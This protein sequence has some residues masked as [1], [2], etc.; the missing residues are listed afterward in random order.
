[1]WGASGLGGKPGRSALELFGASQATAG[2]VAEGEAGAVRELVG[3]GEL[4]VRAFR[5]RYGRDLLKLQKSDSRKAIFAPH[6]PSSTSVVAVVSWG[7]DGVYYLQVVFR[8]SGVGKELSVD[9]AYLREYIEFSRSLNFA[10]AAADLFVSPPTLRAHLHALEEEVGAPLTVKRAG[11][12]E[13]SPAGRLFLKRARAIVKLVEE[14]AE[15]CRALAEASSSMV[16]GTLEYA[17][18]EELL[19]RALLAF[20]RNYPGRCLEVLMASGAY[21]NTEAVAGGKADLSIFAQVRRR[22]EEGEVLP[23]ALPAGVGAFPFAREECR[24]WMNRSCPLFEEDRVRA[25]DLEGFTMLLGSSANMER[26]GRAITEWFAGVG[27]TVEP[28]NQPC[29]NYLDLYLSAAG[30]TFGIALGGAH[31][32]LRASSDIR[33]FAVDDFTVLCD[34]YVIYNEE[35]IGENG[36]LFV[37]CLKESISFSS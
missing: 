33:I 21:A 2:G 28:D 19:T 7:A 22:D 18:F 27:V 30:E 5:K 15:E 32:G 4:A 31:S 1:M 25:A 20:R 17:P 8:D 11:Q 13:L 24:F 35:R 37:E 3:F 6:G 10:Q 23:A 9:T 26:A 36:R 29:S 34:L 16:V 14:S 12:L